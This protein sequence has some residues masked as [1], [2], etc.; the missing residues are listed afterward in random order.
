MNKLLAPAVWCKTPKRVCNVIATRRE[1]DSGETGRCARVL[2]EGSQNPA[3]VPTETHRDARRLQWGAS[4]ASPALVSSAAL[5]KRCRF[6]FRTTLLVMFTVALLGCTASSKYM[7]E[8]Q[9]LVSLQPPPDKAVVVFIR[10]SNF[11]RAVGTT[12]LDEHGRF[13]GDSLPQTYFAVLEPPGQHVFI[14]W[15]ENTAALRAELA[16]GHVYYVEVAPKM[17][18]MSA[19]MHLLALTPRSENWPKLREWLSESKP[20]VAN[21]AAG[22]AYLSERRD[23][24]AERIRRAQEALSK[25]DRDE[26][27]E[28]T[29][30]APD[31]R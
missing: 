9:G 30:F 5:L 20:L 12:I 26:L 17:G 3:S 29:I 28:R 1:R 4:P 23:D 15:A 13:L 25:Y 19:R 24:V 21:E 16:P 11:A 7:I 27:A 22:Q 14:S 2:S 8:P 18:V 31:G 10:P 6:D